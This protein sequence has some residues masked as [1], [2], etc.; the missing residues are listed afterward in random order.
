MESLRTEMS[1]RTTRKRERALMGSKVTCT[2]CGKVW[3][4]NVEYTADTKKCGKNTCPLLPTPPSKR[5]PRQ[6]TKEKGLNV[7]VATAV[8]PDIMSK[9]QRDEEAH[10]WLVVPKVITVEIRRSR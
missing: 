8:I 5:A 3:A 1:K 7:K 9:K 2:T 10:Y 6:A 4:T